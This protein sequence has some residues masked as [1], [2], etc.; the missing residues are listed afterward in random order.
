MAFISASNFG[1]RELT[2]KLVGKKL[3]IVMADI[4]KIALKGD[5]LSEANLWRKSYGN[6][7]QAFKDEATNLKGIFTIDGSVVILES[8]ANLKKSGKLREQD[9]KRAKEVWNNVPTY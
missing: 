8:Y 3:Q 2:I 5:A 1:D 7:K 9:L 6:L 4:S